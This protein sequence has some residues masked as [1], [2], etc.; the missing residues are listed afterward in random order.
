MTGWPGSTRAMYA[1]LTST[2]I[3]LEFMS[4]M[5]ETPVRVSSTGGD[6]RI[7]SPT[8]ASLESRDA[9]ERRAN[10]AVVHCLLGF[11]DARFGASYLH[12]SERDFGLEVSTAVSELSRTS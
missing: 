2:S 1:S 6:G 7:I 9:V 12:L 11:C 5:V 8:C 10:H 3:S 4:T